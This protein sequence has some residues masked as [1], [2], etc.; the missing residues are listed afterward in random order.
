M[1]FKIGHKVWAKPSGHRGYHHATIVMVLDNGEA[2]LLRWR[3]HGWDNSIVCARNLR[4]FIAF[5]GLAVTVSGVRYHN[6]DMA[7]G[8]PH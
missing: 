7:G 6:T 1:V 2:F 4:L 3:K 5:E 8:V